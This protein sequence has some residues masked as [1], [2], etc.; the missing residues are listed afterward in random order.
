M[1]G[2][3]GVDGRGYCCGKR[4]VDGRSFLL[5][6]KVDLSKNCTLGWDLRI[7]NKVSDY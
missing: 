5:K 7:F 6:K 2:L 3:N 1:D 4:G